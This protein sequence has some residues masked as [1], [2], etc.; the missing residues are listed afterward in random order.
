MSAQSTIECA[1]LDWVIVGG[2]SGAGAR[3]MH[4][5][6]ARQIRDA[7]AAAGMAFHF[8]QWGAW[9]DEREATA[10]HLAPGPEMFDCSGCPK[11]PNWHPYD[12]G[13]RNG[14]MMIRVG[15][16]AAGRL[17]DGVEYNG[18]PEARS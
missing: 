5:D 1:I 7:C 10:R 8:K 17:L 6:W 9:L 12:A 16:N 4:P 11:G 3:P 18:M 15:K 2:E 14:G 13:D